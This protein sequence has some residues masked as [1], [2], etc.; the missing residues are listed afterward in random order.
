MTIEELVDL[1]NQDLSNEHK[2][3]RFYL[4]SS[5]NV[6]G[7]ERLFVKGWL[8]GQA[9]EE[10][11][12]IKEFA[13]L[14]AAFGI[15]PTMYASEYPVNL[16]NAQEILSYALQMEQ[17]VIANYH[18]RHR[19]ATE[20]HE[21]TGRYYDIIVFYEDQIEDSQH[22]VDEIVKLLGTKR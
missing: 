16:T 7:L 15:T 4:Q 21:K 5:F 11:G 6:Q 8:E 20:L 14:V 17:E 18:K 9:S 22:D 3:H 13:H 10:L 12:H 1:I 19:Q 2:H